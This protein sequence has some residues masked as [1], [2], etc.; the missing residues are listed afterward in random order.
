MLTRLNRRAV[1]KARRGG[2]E[3]QGPAGRPGYRANAGPRHALRAS[4]DPAGNGTETLTCQLEYSDFTRPQDDVSV[5][6][7]QIDTE[8]GDGKHPAATV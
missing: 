2:R 4:V 1:G 7:G 5:G 3:A 6:D 8:P